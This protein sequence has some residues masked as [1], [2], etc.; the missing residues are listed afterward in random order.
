[1]DRLYDDK[2]DGKIDE[3]FAMRKMSE[4]RDQEHALQTALASLSAPITTENVLT[5]R[6]GTKGAFL[7]LTRNSAERGQLL[8]KVLL[9]CETDGVNLSPTYKK[10]FDLI[11]QRAKNENGRDG[12][13]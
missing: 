1:M 7:Y 13:I 12:Q 6:T 4:Y 2:V 9:K 11:F 3:A 5:V 10:P 8:K